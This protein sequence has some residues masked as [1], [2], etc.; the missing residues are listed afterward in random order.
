[1]Q[2]AFILLRKLRN[3]L[4]G[5]ASYSN[6]HRA[7]ADLLTLYMHTQYW[8]APPPPFA[9]IVGM[10]TCTKDDVAITLCTG[11]TFNVHAGFELFFF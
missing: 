1:M 3:V 5:A 9:Q 2:S 4:R 8:C 11:C 6:V 10:P 7:A